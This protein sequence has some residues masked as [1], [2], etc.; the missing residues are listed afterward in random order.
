MEESSDGTQAYIGLITAAVVLEPEVLLIDE[1]E[2]FLHPPLARRLG[3]DLAQLAEENSSQLIVATHSSDFILGCV[4][5]SKDVT[6]LRLTTPFASRPARAVDPSSLSKFLSH[7]LF[8]SANVV[9]ALF[10]DGAIVTESDNDRAFYSEIYARLRS[11]YPNLPA[12]SFLNAQNK[13]TLREIFGPLRQT[14]VPAAA[15]VD[16]DILKD[17]FIDT[18]NAANVS[19][20]TRDSLNLARGK[21]KDAFDKKS[22]SMKR[23]GDLEKLDV[24]IQAGARDLFDRL[25][26]YGIFVVRRGQLEDW[27]PQLEVAGRGT[28]WTVEMLTRLGIPDGQEGHAP[29][30][31]DDVWAF[32]QKVAEWCANANRLGMPIEA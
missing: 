4:Q 7:P 27:L 24:D 15:I 26:E 25:D 14:G 28:D 18:L 23:S 17:K 9:S 16:A 2:A 11:K 10:H 32:I 20:I 22:L 31:D 30:G 12:L 6:I 3:Q 5:V 19:T 13:Q 8:R 21:V 29:T 1:P